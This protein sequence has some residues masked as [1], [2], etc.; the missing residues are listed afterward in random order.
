MHSQCACSTAQKMRFY[1]KN[2]FSKCD[3][4][5]WKLQAK[6]IIFLDFKTAYPLPYALVTYNTS[7]K[8]SCSIFILI[9][10]KAFEK[11]VTKKICLPLKLCRVFSALGLHKSIEAVENQGHDVTYLPFV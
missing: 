9:F 1:I 2:F 6:E 10:R 4:I 3:Q 5:C 8:L 7:P 11:H